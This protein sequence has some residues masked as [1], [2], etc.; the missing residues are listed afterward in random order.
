MHGQ[1]GDQRPQNKI[2]GDGADHRQKMSHLF[3]PDV[4]CSNS[5]HPRSGKIPARKPVSSIQQGRHPQADL[6]EEVE[7]QYRQTLDHH[8]RQHPDEDLVQCHVR[9]R[10]P[11]QVEGGHR[12]RR[13]EERR[14]EVQGHEQTEKSGLMSKCARSG[15]KIGMKMTMISVHSSGQPSRKMITCA[16]SMNWVGVMSIDFTQVLMIS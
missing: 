13:R 5:V 8:E 15:M 6:R 7:K 16:S 12:D 2:T 14:L 4:G 9:R 10:H 3:P 11:L 1:D